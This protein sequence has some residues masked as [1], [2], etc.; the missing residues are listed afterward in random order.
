[1]KAKKGSVYIL[2]HVHTDE[3]LDGGEDVKLLGVFS[4]QEKALEAQT[5]ASALP[6]FRDD[7]LGFEISMYKIDEVHWQEGYVTVSWQVP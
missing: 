1:M 4:S 5:T 6:G 2:W 7:L 3:K